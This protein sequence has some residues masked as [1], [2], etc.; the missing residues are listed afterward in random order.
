MCGR[1][2]LIALCVGFYQSA[3]MVTGLIK[4]RDQRRTEFNLP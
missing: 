1:H 3:E 4:Q 2:I